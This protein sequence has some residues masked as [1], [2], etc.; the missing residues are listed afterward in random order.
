MLLQWRNVDELTYHDHIL[1]SCAPQ[2][3]R[4][5]TKSKFNVNCI[6]IFLFKIQYF[7]TQTAA[8]AFRQ[9]SHLSS[10]CW[11]DI[12]TVTAGLQ[13]CFQKKKNNAAKTH[14]GKPQ[15]GKLILIY[16]MQYFG[17]TS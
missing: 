6:Y 17:S 9:P 13:L 16:K 14:V 5:N 7:S 11:C 4:S 2:M 12:Y 1:G 8:Q 3:I 10:D 15:A